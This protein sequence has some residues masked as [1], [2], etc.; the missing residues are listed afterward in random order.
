MS[1][2]FDFCVTDDI[3]LIQEVQNLQNILEVFKTG[4][5]NTVFIPRKFVRQNLQM[6]TPDKFFKSVS[7]DR[8]CT[9]VA[10][11]FN[12]EDF[13]YDLT[14]NTFKSARFHYFLEDIKKWN[15]VRHQNVCTIFLMYQ[16][17][18]F[19]IC[20]LTL[21]N[22]QKPYNR[23]QVARF[24]QLTVLAE[25]SEQQIVKIITKKRCCSLLDF[26]IQDCFEI[27]SCL[28]KCSVAYRSEKPGKLCISTSLLR[29]QYSLHITNY[30]NSPDFWY[31]LLDSTPIYSNIFVQRISI[32]S[33]KLC[34]S[35]MKTCARKKV[36]TYWTAKL[37]TKRALQKE[38]K[39]SR[40]TCKSTTS[41]DLLELQ[42]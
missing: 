17:C 25:M 16:L 20:T 4:A 21:I 42:N 39:C 5:V 30:S 26:D 38:D 3:E 41:T 13:L 15:S 34:A 11:L 2:T 28:K 8:L 24:V 40:D 19:W 12:L 33:S 9:L 22:P 32:E 36:F 18:N 23:E 10:Y 1:T 14:G 31:N 37:C 7:H 27:D 6:Y 29:I 35:A